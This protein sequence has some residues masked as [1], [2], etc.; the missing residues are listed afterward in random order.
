MSAQAI[1]VMSGVILLLL[2]ALVAWNV[3]RRSGHPK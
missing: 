2:F 1:T 3:R